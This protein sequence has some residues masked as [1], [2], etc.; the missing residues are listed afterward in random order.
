MNSSRL[1]GVILIL[2]LSS[3]QQEKVESLEGRVHELE[4]ELV[5]IKME[6]ARLNAE[7]V[8]NEIQKNSIRALSDDE[9]IQIVKDEL[10]FKCPKTPTKDFVVKKVN[11]TYYKIRFYQK[12]MEGQKYEWFP[13]FYQVKLLPGDRYSCYIHGG[14]QCQE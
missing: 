14:K 7:I 6:N 10:A 13:V 1:I 9:V 4:K 11:E 12:F 2:T 3:C 8:N 5:D